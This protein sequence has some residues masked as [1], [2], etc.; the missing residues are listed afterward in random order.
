MDLRTFDWEF[1]EKADKQFSKLDHTV[2]KRIFKWLD[3]HITGQEN[4]RLIGDALEGEF[5]NYWRYKIGKYR[6]I[7]DIED[8]KFLVLVIKVGKREDAYKLHK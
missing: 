2:K 4:P 1:T 3:T 8:D 5:K 7:A 6:I